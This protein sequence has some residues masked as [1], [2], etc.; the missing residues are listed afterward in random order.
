MLL[1]GGLEFASYS[2]GTASCIFPLPP[3]CRA[4]NTPQRGVPLP[5]TGQITL[6]LLLPRLY[7]FNLSAERLKLVLSSI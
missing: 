6:E 5:T 4:M 2:E 1:G 3:R 7:T